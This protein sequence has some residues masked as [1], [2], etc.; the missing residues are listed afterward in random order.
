M[1]EA[2][3]Y[4]ADLMRKIKKNRAEF[5]KYDGMKDEELIESLKQ[6]H[7]DKLEFKVEIERFRKATG[8]TDPK[9]LVD[10]SKYPEDS[11]ERKII[12]EF[13][14]SRTIYS[15]SREF[16]DTPFSNEW[17]KMSSSLTKEEEEAKINEIYPPLKQ[18]YESA[19]NRLKEEK[20][21]GAWRS[22]PTYRRY[23]DLNT[24][25]TVCF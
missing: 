24:T 5:K 23:S 6:E 11:W 12:N 1:I 25:Y 2:K 9:E 13:N 16:S 17:V 14:R 4:K 22:T 19:L 21:I 8:I 15:T 10:G 20:V 7:R 18:A 3:G